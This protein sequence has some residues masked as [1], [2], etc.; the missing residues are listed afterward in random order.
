MDEVSLPY[1]L[2]YAWRSK[3]IYT[4]CDFWYCVWITSQKEAYYS[5]ITHQ[6]R[7]S[8]GVTWISRNT[9][10]WCLIRTLRHQMIQ[11]LQIIWFQVH[12][13]AFLLYQLG[14][15]KWIRMFYVYTG[16]VLKQSKMITM[17]ALYRIVKKVN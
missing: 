16:W 4:W 7:Y 5:K 1:S 13:N 15:Y 9:A 11:L 17:V 2:T 12:M 3:F 8:W 6:G 10:R 14:I